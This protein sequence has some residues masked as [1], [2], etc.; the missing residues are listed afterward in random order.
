MS[1][2]WQ[3]FEVPDHIDKLAEDAAKEK[4]VRKYEFIKLVVGDAA[5]EVLNYVKETREETSE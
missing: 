1:K 5:R 3:I 4:G 2:R